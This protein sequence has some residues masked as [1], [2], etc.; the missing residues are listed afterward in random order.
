MFYKNYA[1]TEHGG[2][3]YNPSTEGGQKF[4]VKASL[5]CKARSYLKKKRQVGVA[6]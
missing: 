5:D 6:S 1:C 4:K 3:P 2:T